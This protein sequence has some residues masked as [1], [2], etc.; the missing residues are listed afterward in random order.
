MRS[1]R[2]VHYRFFDSSTISILLINIAIDDLQSNQIK[3]KIFLE[4][5]SFLD[6]DPVFTDE[7]C[8]G[9]GGGSEKE[10]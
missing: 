10:N 1:L 8:E 7:V 4:F 5:P 2:G 9:V 3:I 6:I